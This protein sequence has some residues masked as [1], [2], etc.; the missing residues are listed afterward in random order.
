MS[1]FQLKY[2]WKPVAVRNRNMERMWMSPH[3]SLVIQR[4]FHSVQY[5]IRPCGTMNSTT[6]VTAM[7]RNPD[8]LN[9]EVSPRQCHFLLVI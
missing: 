9:S 8:K 3:C 2:T 5:A 6:P 4:S 7:I 1:G